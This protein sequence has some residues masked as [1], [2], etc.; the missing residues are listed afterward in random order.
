[1]RGKGKVTGVFLLDWAMMAVSL[2]NTVLLLWLGFTVLLNA[3]RRTWGVWLAGLGLLMGGAFFVSHSAMLGH[4]LHYATRGMEFWWRVGWVPVVALPDAWYVVM[5]WYAGFWADQDAPLR[6]RHRV[7]FVLTAILALLIVGLFLFASPLPSYW[8]VAQLEWAVTPLVAGVPLL[9]LIYPLYV[10]L[11]IVLS[12]D[13]LGHPGFSRRLMGDLARRRAHPWLVATSVVLLLVSLLVAGSMAWILLGAQRRLVDDVYEAMALAV[14]GLDLVISS[15]ISVS[16]FLLGQ[17]IVSYEVF[18][19]KTLPRRGFLRHWCNAVILAVGY[20]A[21]VSWTLVIQLRPIYNL[22][23]TAVLMVSFYALLSWRSFAERE[24]TMAQLR[25]FAASQRLYDSLLAPSASIPPDV[26]APT[27][28]RALCEQVLGVQQA[29]LVPLGPLAP[30]LGSPLVYPEGYRLLRQPVAEVVARFEPTQMMY[31]PLDP[32]QHGGARWAVPLW[33]ARGLVGALLLGDKRDGGLYSEE[34]IEIARAGGERL[35]DTLATVE[36]A[37]RLMALL[38]QRIAQ[39]RVMDGQGRRVLHD[40]ILPRLHSA[41]LYLSGVQ[42]NPAVE[43]AVEA[44]TAAHH[45]ISD[46]MR[47]AALDAPQRLAERGLVAALRAFVERDVRHESV[48]VVWQ[49]APEAEASACQLPFFVGEVVYFAAQELIRNAAR[50]GR[51]GDPGRALQLGIALTLEQGLCLA[52]ED[53]GVGFSPDEG[54]EPENVTGA[55]QGLRFHST[56]LA[57]LGARLEVMALPKG[58]TRGMITV[59]L[60]AMQEFTG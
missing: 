36:T 31:L 15:L 32:A 4:D 9:F 17:A 2:L 34:E 55:G 30:L 6:R 29:C 37:R 1:L 48:R 60:E 10:V 18:T 21:L 5:L 27:L 38:R 14:A 16:V 47:D 44:L 56:M 11:C 35:L 50:H 28:F 54:P 26:D 24:R 33:S 40:H 41:I 57:A 25:P 43:R 52:V 22:L 12:L 8:Q 42:G 58:G 13:A 19:G 53:D 23:L 3:E 46:L 49:V 59:P 7:W 51:G 39:V 45:Q 20:S